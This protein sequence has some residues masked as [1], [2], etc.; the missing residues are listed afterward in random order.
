MPFWPFKKSEPEQLTPVELRDKLIQTAISGS[1]RQLRSLCQ[2]HNEQVANNVEFLAKIPEEI[3]SDE[4][5][6]NQHVQAMIAIAQ[7]LANECRSPQLWQQL[8]GGPDDNPLLAL[9][10]WFDDFPKRMQQLEFESLIS[11]AES[12]LEKFQTLKGTNAGHYETFVVGRLGELFFQSGNV[13]SAFEL[14]GKALDRCEKAGD[15]EGQIV[16]L[17]N[18][19]EA[20]RYLGQTEEALKCRRQALL[21]TRQHGGDTESIERRIAVMEQGEPLCRVICLRDGVQ[22]ELS[23]ITSVGEGSY[24]FQFER[25]RISLQKTGILVQQGN[26]LASSGQYSDA[27]EKYNEASEV[28]PHDP[29]PV[30]QS[31]MCLLE[32]GA[33]AKAREAFEEV[34]RLAPGW[35]RCRT[36]CWIADGL[37]KGTISNEEFMLVRTLDD[38]GLSDKQ[39]ASL[40][41]QG[42]ERFPDFAPLYLLLGDRCNKE[43]DAI[44]AYR[45]G[46]ELVEEPDLESRLLCA[47]AGRL[48]ADSSERKHLVE[49]AVKLDGSLIALATAKLM[50]LQ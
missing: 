39:A 50:G 26:H 29:D 35:F 46:L 6:T 40:A 4:V 20:H 2:R 34:E 12:H 10:Q 24:K 18:L 38:G 30:Y 41:R 32:L 33:Y 44:A 9:D 16:Y 8:T 17:N 23:E 11:E 13:E 14:F 49:R 27:L 15:F 43:V 5:K 45:K 22:F 1:N 21:I 25:N 36:D 42:V 47:L 7:C 37:D 19:H 28:D 31:G 3:Q 48:P